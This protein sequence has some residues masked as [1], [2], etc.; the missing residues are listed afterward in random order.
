MIGYFLALAE[1]ADPERT[2]TICVFHD[3][4]EARTGDIPSV[5]KHYL[6]AASPEDVTSDQSQGL[7]G[8]FRSALKGLIDMT[9]GSGSPEAACARDADKLE[10]LLQAREY[11]R[12]GHP[13]VQPWIDSMVAAVRR[14]T[15]KAMAS[16]ALDAD[17]GEW[18]RD[19][20]SSYGAKLADWEP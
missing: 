2:A 17:P 10:C 4:A 11:Q 15:G 5:G 16:A 14:A 6:A 3:L 20:A 19:M 8:Q 12:E 1:G 13:D 9:H 7:P 18:W